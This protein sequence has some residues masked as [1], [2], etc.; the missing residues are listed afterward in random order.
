MGRPRKRH[1]DLA[2]TLSVYRPAIA[3]PA[4]ALLPHPVALAA[5]SLYWPDCG[6]LSNGTVARAVEFSEKQISRQQLRLQPERAQSRRR[7]HPATEYPVNHA[8]NPLR[9][10]KSE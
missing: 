1:A 5:A 6:V 9:R 4:A 2:R 7:R 8:I 10:R 3:E